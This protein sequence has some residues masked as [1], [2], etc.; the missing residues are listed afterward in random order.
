MPIGSVKSS[1]NGDGARTKLAL[2]S[3]SEILQ[4]KEALKARINGN[5]NIASHKQFRAEIGLGDYQQS[6]QFFRQQ[7]INAGNSIGIFS[8]FQVSE[9]ATLDDFKRL[10]KE[11]AGYRPQNFKYQYGVRANNVT[12]ADFDE[13]QSRYW[14]EQDEFMSLNTDR[15]LTK[16]L[17]S[18]YK[19]LISMEDQY[20][21]LVN[22]GDKIE[23]FKLKDSIE[24]FKSQI[25]VIKLN[26]VNELS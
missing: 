9:G 13:E 12:L 7:A 11:V 3:N 10:S 26:R 17:E 4:D 2:R 22:S 14:Q 1:D 5:S 21:E 24:R 25:D 20:R 19:I 18:Q 6:A 8:D 15:L 23:S 16:E